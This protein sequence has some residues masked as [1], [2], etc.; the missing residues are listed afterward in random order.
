MSMASALTGSRILTSP[1]EEAAPSPGPASTALC[2]SRVTSDSDSE[3]ILVTAPV[4]DTGDKSGAF[5]VDPAS[6]CPRDSVRPPPSS[7]SKMP[8]PATRHLDSELRA[9]R[10]K[11]STYD[12]RRSGAQGLPGPDYKP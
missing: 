8:P 4:K 3:E 10:S 2:D 9:R 6:F 1:T 5:Q 11:Y 7:S 12:R